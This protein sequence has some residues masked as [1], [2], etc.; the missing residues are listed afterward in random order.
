MFRPL[1]GI[2]FAARR[3]PIPVQRYRVG[4][5]M[6]NELRAGYKDR[7]LHIFTHAQQPRAAATSFSRQ[8]AARCYYARDY[9]T[10]M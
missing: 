10:V 8:F 6:H 2:I 4:L 1:G 7:A 9:R 5:S 3:E